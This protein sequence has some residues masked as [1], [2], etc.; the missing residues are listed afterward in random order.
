MKKIK[1]NENPI[2]IKKRMKSLRKGNAR[3]IFAI[4]CTQTAEYL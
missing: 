1:S 4:I 2:I 3:I